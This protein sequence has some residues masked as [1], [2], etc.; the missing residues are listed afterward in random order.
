[1]EREEKGG[2]PGLAYPTPVHLFT[3]DD[4]ASSI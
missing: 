1:M 3:P 2:G 4:A